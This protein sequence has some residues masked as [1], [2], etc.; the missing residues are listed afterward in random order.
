MPKKRKPGAGRPP[1]PAN[2][3]KSCTITIKLTPGEDAEIRKA[4]TSAGLTIRD[5]LVDR[6]L[7]LTRLAAIT[8]AADR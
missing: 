6:S 4:A 2:S 3:R 1:K 8:A 5:F 7:H